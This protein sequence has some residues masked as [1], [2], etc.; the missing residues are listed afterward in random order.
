MHG[1]PGLR[2]D[3]LGGGGGCHE[4]QEVCVAHRQCWPE[5]DGEEQTLAGRR[6]PH[7]PQPPTARR[8]TFGD[9]D[10]AFGRPVC[11]Q[12]LR[13]G[14][15]GFDLVVVAQRASEQCLASH[16]RDERDG[17]AAGL[18]FELVAAVRDAEDAISAAAK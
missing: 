2:L 9:D 12:R 15:R 18:F 17:Q 1:Y 13:L 16:A 11:G 3:G 10:R 14:V 6:G 8:L 7:A 5:D 4:R